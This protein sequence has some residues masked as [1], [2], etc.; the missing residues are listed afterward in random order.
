[1]SAQS[2]KQTMPQ[3]AIAVTMG[4]PAGIGGEVTL[5]AWQNRERLSSPFFL[6]DDPKRIERLTQN[7]GMSVPIKSIN[8]PE[9][10]FQCF[11]TH[12]PVLPIN[13]KI[14]I[15]LGKPHIAY[16][17]AVINS[18][19]IGVRLVTSGKASALT[20]NPIQKEILYQAGFEYPGH[21]E[22]LAHLA[23]IETPPVMMLASR[24]LL[25][26]PV[27]IHESLLS[28]VQSLNAAD[29]VEKTMIANSALCRDFALAKPRLA[30]A[31]L[32]PHAGEGGTLG[33]EEIDIIAPA[34]K[35]L[36]VKGLDVFGP[37]PP[38]TLFS[39]KIRET[40]DAA[41]CM[42]HDQALIPIKT[43]DF[44]GA[45]NV[46]CGLPFIRTSPDH[47]TAID[48]ARKGTASPESLVA[49]LNMAAAMAANR[50][51]QHAPH[52]QGQNGLVSA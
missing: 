46:T 25:V 33:N 29:I 35:Q 17:A 16:A 27:T 19:E 10:A 38:D 23:S 26:V 43:L 22:F 52:T 13:K 30:I 45:V 14:D 34:I 32:N 9:E 21:T 28:A 18:I 37:V 44:E 31:G 3:N 48:I 4:E 15:N 7:F 39:E 6:I 20:T 50:H 24:V 42:Y 8:T 5:K 51:Q 11:S 2:A 36:K 49:A 1:M 41:I 12:L 40:Y 47:G